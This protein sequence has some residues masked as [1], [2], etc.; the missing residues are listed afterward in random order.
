MRNKKQERPYKLFSD[1]AMPKRLY[2]QWEIIKMQILKKCNVEH[3]FYWEIKVNQKYFDNVI[4]NF[5]WKVVSED[6]P[7][8]AEHERTKAQAWFKR[9]YQ[10]GNKLFADLELTKDG[11]ENI[12]WWHYKYFSVEIYDKYAMQDSG[13][14]YE[15]VLVGW[16]FTNYPFF[17]GMEKAFSDK[18]DETENI[19]L[20]FKNPESMDKIK[21]MLE[22]FKAEKKLNFADKSALILAFSE[23][24]EEEKKEVATEVE[25]AV[26]TVEA[27]KEEEKEE[28]EKEEEGKEKDKKE[29]A[30]EHSNPEMEAMKKEL[31]TLKSEKRF[32]EV[33]K[34]FSTIDVISKAENFSNIAKLFAKFSDEETEELHKFF[35]KVNEVVNTL[36][37]WQISQVYARKDWDKEKKVDKEGKEEIDE[38]EMSSKVNKLM[39]EKKCSRREAYNEVSEKYKCK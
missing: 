22:K 9:V 23:L 1:L 4:R 25:T 17:R 12:N 36:T 26:E 16:A 20:T 5:D 29:E 3:P 38:K 32:S 35:S 8:N 30:Q 39:E 21:T 28:E 7:V 31:A 27:P 34:K 2:S 10:E 18:A 11:S 6:L 19:Y 15:N 33:E 13:D 24:D 14:K 37:S